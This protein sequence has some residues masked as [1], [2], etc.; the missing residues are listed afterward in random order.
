MATNETKDKAGAN[1]VVFVFIDEDGN[2]IA[3]AAD[4]KKGGYGGY[5]LREAQATRAY[6]A[7]AMKVCE[8]YSC[9]RL[10]RAI[11]PY[12]ARQIMRRL[13][14]KHGCSVHRIDIPEVKEVAR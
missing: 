2:A 5:T 9:D 13:V 11:E 3:N 8:A 7:L 10:V 6:E 1:G 14:D 4:F 12:D